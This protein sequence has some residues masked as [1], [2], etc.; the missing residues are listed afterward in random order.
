[1]A[2]M[3]PRTRFRVAPQHTMTQLGNDGARAATYLRSYNSPKHF[4]LFYLTHHVHVQMLGSIYLLHRNRSGSRGGM[5]VPRAAV[6]VGFSG[7]CERRVATTSR[8]P[9]NNIWI[10]GHMPLKASCIL[11]IVFMNIAQISSTTGF[12][13]N[14]QAIATILE[15]ARVSSID[16][17]TESISQSRDAKKYLWR[18]YC[19]AYLE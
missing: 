3:T 6:K 4:Y 15:T 8:P 2:R 19:A 18:K 1:M 11:L 14:A 13:S 16:C 12:S 9:L 17:G 5:S 10:P 7:S